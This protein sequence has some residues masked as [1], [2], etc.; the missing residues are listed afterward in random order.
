MVISERFQALR[1][2]ILLFRGLGAPRCRGPLLVGFILALFAFSSLIF[3]VKLAPSDRVAHFVRVGEEP[4]TSTI[5]LGQLRPSEQAELIAEVP[6]WYK[7]A[8]R[9]SW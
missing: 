9:I 6:R 3:A 8:S 2:R 4:S 7:A 5:E 1:D